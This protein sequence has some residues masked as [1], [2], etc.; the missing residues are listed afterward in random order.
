MGPG[1]IPVCGTSRIIVGLFVC[2]FFNHLCFC[3]CFQLEIVHDCKVLK[4]N[5]GKKLDLEMF[6]PSPK[7]K[8]GFLRQLE[9]LALLSL[10]LAWDDQIAHL[11]VARRQAT[12]L[13]DA[14]T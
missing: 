1:I 2:L 5:G 9:F 12:Y 3:F 8:W 6:F 7:K 13:I 4:F 11:Q 14:G 10:T